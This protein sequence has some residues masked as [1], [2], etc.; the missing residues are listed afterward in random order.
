[1]TLKI[2]AISVF[3]VII[4]KFQIDRCLVLIDMR[5]TVSDDNYRCCVLCTFDVRTHEYHFLSKQFHSVSQSSSET[6]YA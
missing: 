6:L 3:V 1:M 2:E 5:Q 4:I